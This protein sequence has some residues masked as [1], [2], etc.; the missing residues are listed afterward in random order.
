MSEEIRVN[1]GNTES[2]IKQSLQPANRAQLFSEYKDLVT[3][4]QIFGDL[5]VVKGIY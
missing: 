5:F 3:N 4:V 2:S 1:S